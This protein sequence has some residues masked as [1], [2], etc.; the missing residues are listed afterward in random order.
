M[1]LFAIRFGH[2]RNPEDVFTS[3]AIVKDTCTDKIHRCREGFLWKS[4]P[5]ARGDDLFKLI[6]LPK[7][8]GNGCK[9]LKLRTI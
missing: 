5:F 3:T 2:R 4:T 1:F 6:D 7:P 8:H 9:W